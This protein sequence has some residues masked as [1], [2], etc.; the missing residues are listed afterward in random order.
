MD[1]VEDEVPS[2]EGLASSPLP[3]SAKDP[4]RKAI[5]SQALVDRWCQ[6]VREK[7][8]TAAFERLMKVRSRHL[9]YIREC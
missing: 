4:G 2:E 9:L 5:L 8:A 1:L 3:V 7:G 6:D